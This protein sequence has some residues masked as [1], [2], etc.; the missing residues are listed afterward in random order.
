VTLLRSVVEAG[1]TETEP[2]RA[3][4]LEEAAEVPVTAHLRDRDAVRIEVVTQPP[5]ERPDSGA[6]ARSLHEDDRMEFRIG[7]PAASLGALMPSFRCAR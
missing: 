3:V 5:G 7:H 6:V 4:P 1:Q 2:G